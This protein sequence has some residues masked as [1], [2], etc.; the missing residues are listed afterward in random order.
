MKKSYSLLLKYLIITTI[1]LIIPAGCSFKNEDKTA[2]GNTNYDPDNID[3]DHVYLY[4]SA[5]GKVCTTDNDTQTSPVENICVILSDASGNMVDSVRTNTY[6]RFLIEHDNV[7]VGFP[8]DQH[9]YLD[10]IDDRPLIEPHNRLKPLHIIKE[11]SAAPNNIATLSLDE[12]ILNKQI[13]E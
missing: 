11:I 4:V 8:N 2:A 3:D 12:I 5:D 6:G 1:V 9:I 7:N 10:I 13:A